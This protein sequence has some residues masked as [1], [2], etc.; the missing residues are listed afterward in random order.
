MHGNV[1]FAVPRYQL[2]RDDAKEQDGFGLIQWYQNSKDVVD[3]SEI[4]RSP[5]DMVS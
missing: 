2:G 4:R 3:G 1:A 5:V